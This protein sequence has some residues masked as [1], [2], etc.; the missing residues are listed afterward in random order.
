MRKLS[1]S[2]WFSLWVLLIALVVFPGMGTAGEGDIYLTDADLVPSLVESNDYTCQSSDTASGDGFYR[3][4]W[5]KPNAFQLPGIEIDFGT[6]PAGKIWTTLELAVRFEDAKGDIEIPLGRQSVPIDAGSA[7]YNDTI[8][9]AVGK[10]GELKIGGHISTSGGTP[11]G[12][13]V[14]TARY[15]EKKE[16][17][18]IAIL[19]A[20]GMNDTAASWDLFKKYVQDNTKYKCFAFDVSPCGEIADRAEQLAEHIAKLDLPDESLVAVGH[21]MGGLDLRYIIGA[22][23]RGQEKFI[24]AAR[25]IKHVFTI[26]TPHQGV[27]LADVKPDWLDIICSPAINNLKPE[28]LDQFNRDYPYSRFNNPVTG[29]KILFMAYHYQCQ[30]MGMDGMV[31]TSSQSWPK[32]PLENNT[33]DGR[34]CEMRI[35]NKCTAELQQSNLIEDIIGR[36]KFIP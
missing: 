23:N 35:L 33:R 32:A 14:A 12:K 8:I 10:S 3:K 31:R 4:C 34:H 21:S 27:Y 11:R 7:R 18:S 13:I 36:V 29:K 5:S 28:F 15:A 9:L 19:F 25:K 16:N 22:A 17:A 2:L 24:R 6:P 26:A 30:G 20:H 1:P